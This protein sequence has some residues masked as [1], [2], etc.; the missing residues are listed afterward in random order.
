M[1][2]LHNKVLIIDPDNH[3]SSFLRITLDMQGFSVY[4]SPTGLSG[5]HLCTAINPDIILLDPN[6]PDIYA[7]DLFALLRNSKNI[8]IIIISDK[9]SESDKVTAF[10]YGADDYITKPFGMSELIAR[11]RAALRHSFAPENSIKFQT[12]RLIIDFDKREVTL[13]NEIIRLTAT[14]YALISV[15]AK[16]AGKVLTYN[17]II[18]RIWGKNS[19]ADVKRLHVNMANIRRKLSEPCGKPNYIL[20]E[21]GVG[22]KMALIK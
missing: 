7:K 10:S 5:A 3:T 13:K 16:S 17:Q 20:T 4:T 15:L 19:T 9:T 8:P 18:K 22:Y 11:M 14:E 6:V 21:N 1:S 2:N 12:G